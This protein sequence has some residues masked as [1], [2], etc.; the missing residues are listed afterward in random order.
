MVKI[1]LLNE[2][3]IKQYSKTQNTEVAKKDI[4]GIL[5]LNKG[6]VYKIESFGSCY[7]ILI[8]IWLINI[9]LN[10][11]PMCYIKSSRFPFFNT[12]YLN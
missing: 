5:H 9:R 12:K 1:I 2:S 3:R 11:A 10:N 4:I 7:N 6:S 8:C